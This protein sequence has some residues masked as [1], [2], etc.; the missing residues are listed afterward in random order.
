[1]K[2]DIYGRPFLFKAI[3][4]SK[5]YTTHTG[6]LLT[7][8][9]IALLCLISLQIILDF[10]DTK[11]PVVSVN[12][13]KMS[14]APYLNLSMH[15]IGAGSTI[16]NGYKILTTEEIKRYATIRIEM[17]TTI[18]D[19]NGTLV[20]QVEKLGMISCAN[21]TNNDF[22]KEL[23][24]AGFEDE[25]NSVTYSAL[26]LHSALCL[27]AKPENWYIMGSKSNLPYR[28]YVIRVYPCSLEDPSQCAGMRELGT[29]LFG[30]APM[31]K[32]ANYSDKGKPLRTITDADTILYIY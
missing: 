17:L 12:R 2:L 9:G 32:I 26:F 8:L 7:I 11:N 10:L 21:I 13:I 4:R 1:M 15:K 22:A 24:E 19:Q 25:S 27:D 3:N 20:D 30:V 18:R 29:T 28:R 16:F 23:A 5:S 6:G 31:T 14:K